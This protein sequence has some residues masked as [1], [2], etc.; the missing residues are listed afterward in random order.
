MN[1][2]DLIK[3]IVYGPKADSR[4]Y[5]TH[6]R[7]LGMSIGKDVIIYAPTKTLIDESYPWLITIGDNVKVA[8]G[9]IIL[10]HDYSW[11]VLKIRYNGVILGASGKINIGNNVFIGMNA[12]I[13]RGV[14]IG[15]NVVI[16]AGSVVTKDCLPNGVYAGVPAC[17]IAELD[18]FFENRKHSQLQEAKELAVEY[19][20]RYGRIPPE[21][22]FHEF[23]ML[24]ETK[25]SAVRKKWCL[26]KL[27]LCDNFD[28]S[29]LHMANNEPI[30]SD[31]DSFIEFCF[32]STE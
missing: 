13:T 5:I 15:D 18:D 23:F 26:E 25:E 22:I 4:S 20:K 3:K 32:Q 21:E 10:V 16:G 28:E 27:A 31:F 30:F 29:L 14:N 11:S 24:F 19:N 9:A 2:K 12:I 8:Q 7:K 6:L 1:L 17:R